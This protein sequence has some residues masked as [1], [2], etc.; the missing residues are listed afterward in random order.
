MSEDLKKGDHVSWKSYGG[1]AHGKVVTRQTSDT[2]IKG[3]QVRASKDDPQFIVES[4][5][6]GKAA[7]KPGALTKD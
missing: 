7:H 1:T 2:K 6:G 3:H 4:E 5:N